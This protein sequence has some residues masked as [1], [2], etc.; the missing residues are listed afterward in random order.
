MPRTS[1]S[2]SF[3][4]YD[5]SATEE[6]IFSADDVQPFVDLDS[7]KGDG[8]ST[9]KWATYEEDYFEGDGSFW[10]LPSN[11]E[12]YDWGYWS[13]TQGEDEPPTLRV[14][15][16]SAHSSP[17]LTLTF[18]EFTDD[19]PDEL[20]ITWHGYEGEILFANTY[21]PDS[22]KFYAQQ[23]VNNYFAVDITFASMSKAKRFAKLSR[24][25]HGVE[26]FFDREQLVA[27]TLLEE[28]NPTGAEIPINTL[29]FDLFSKDPYFS[30]MKPG[31]VYLLLQELQPLKVT[32]RIDKRTFEMGTYYLEEWNATTDR[33]LSLKGIDL[34]GLLDKKT[35]MGGIYS[36]VRVYDLV[37]DLFLAFDTNVQR[38][39]LDPSLYEIKVSGWLPVCTY[40]EALQQVAFAIGALVDTGRGNLVEIMPTSEDVDLELSLDRKFIGQQLKME[41]VVTAVSVVSH[42]YSAGSERK[43]VFKGTMDEGQH[44]VTFSEPVSDLQITGGSID[45]SGENYAML[46]VD[47][48]GEV[49]VTG[50][51]YVDSQAVFTAQKPFIG[52]GESENTLWVKDATLL[53]RERAAQKAQQLYD[54]YLQRHALTTSFILGTETVGSMIDVEAFSQQWMRGRIESLSINLVG[55]FITEAQIRGEPIELPETE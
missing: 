17:G 12:A 6:S 11:P 13:L 43:E 16:D 9:K 54:Y 49:V 29:S 30:I 38:Y 36:D 15:F 4:L 41:K 8:S 55:G 5:V 18:Y 44:L 39:H 7:L 26:I 3:G 25:D 51:L 10:L 47:T 27:G 42:E 28:V 2:I 21:H 14:D 45:E 23:Q 52:T 40:R 1:A 20:L 48:P 35:F 37:R 34:I 53:S 50:L 31:G 46:V 19:Y 33:N 32:G 22:A 24:L